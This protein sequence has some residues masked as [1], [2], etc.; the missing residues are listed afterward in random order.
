MS[1]ASPVHFSR[2]TGCLSH[3]GG[4]MCVIQFNEQI[5]IYQKQNMMV[6]ISF[7]NQWEHSSFLMDAWIFIS[8]W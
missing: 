6:H 4:L 7:F 5:R 2:M 8:R 3:A 1:P